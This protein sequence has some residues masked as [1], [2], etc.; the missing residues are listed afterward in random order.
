MSVKKNYKEKKFF[1][2]TVYAVC[3][4]NLCNWICIRTCIYLDYK[5][6]PS[7]NEDF[8]DYLSAMK[9][10]SSYLIGFGYLCI[11]IYIWLEKDMESVTRI[12]RIIVMC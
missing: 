10:A 1:C 11:Y 6:M 9:R 8:Q 4:F 2:C 3:R 12:F 5:D 7:C